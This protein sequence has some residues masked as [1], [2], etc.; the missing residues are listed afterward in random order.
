MTPAAP[1]T[2]IWHSEMGAPPE[3]V[4]RGR[5]SPRRAYP[6]L[7]SKE[8]RE[9]SK[10]IRNKES[11]AAE[12]EEWRSKVL[13]LFPF[14]FLSSFLSFHYYFPFLSHLFSFS[15]PLFSYT[16]IEKNI[17]FYLV[18]LPISPFLNFFSSIWSTWSGC[19]H[20][21]VSCWI[22]ANLSEGMDRARTREFFF[23]VYPTESYSYLT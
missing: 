10:F 15:F 8:G 20:K 1:I 6:T 14:S 4:W 12:E 22:N 13:S 7:L 3:C 16:N 2:S 5:R 23:G 11:N 18:L 17:R 9:Q 21:R 19:V